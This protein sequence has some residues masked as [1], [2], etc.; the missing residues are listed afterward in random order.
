[1]EDSVRDI[2]DTS[3]APVFELKGPQKKKRKGKGL[4][5]YLKKL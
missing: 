1:M 2:W 3:N 4:R 5:K